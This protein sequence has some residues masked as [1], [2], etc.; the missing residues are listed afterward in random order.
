M[1]SV[2]ICSECLNYEAVHLVSK[3]CYSKQ[4]C[5]VAVSNQTFQDP[6]F[7]G[8]RKYLSVAY[9][10]GKTPSASW[11]G[12]VCHVQQRAFHNKDLGG[13]VL[14]SDLVRVNMF[15]W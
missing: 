6:C 8:T 12:N 1:V 5:V 2:S 14:V 11:G 7:P 9:S 4:K 3:S 15:I 13:L 10:C